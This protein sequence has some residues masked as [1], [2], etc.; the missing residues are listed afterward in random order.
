MIDSMQTN[1]VRGRSSFPDPQPPNVNNNSNNIFFKEYL[2]HMLFAGK[3]LNFWEKYTLR[4]PKWDG[5]IYLGKT[6]LLMSE[7]GIGDEIIAIRFQK[8]ISDL[9][10]NC[11]WYTSRKD[12]AAVFYQ[13][14]FNVITSLNEIKNDWLWIQAMEA[15]VWLD[16]DYNQVYYGPYLKAKGSIDKL[17]GK[18]KIGLKFSGNLEYDQQI[19]RKIPSD[20]LVDCMPNN[21]TLY[22]FQVFDDEEFISNK[23]ILLRDRI[24]SWEDTLN[25][26]D[27]MDLIVSNCT[28]LP[29]ASSAMGKKTI[30]IVPISSYYIWEKET[31]HS[32][33]Y[34]KSTLILRQKQY[35]NFE[36]PLNQL[37][38]Y[39]IEKVTYDE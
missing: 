32:N 24:S 23:V 37:K 26:I 1:I 34:G 29:H 36:E 17:P 30:V 15:P 7:A 18:Y 2:K 5:K 6:I 27:Q 9:G 16:L 10:M 21:A 22:S 11:V 38:K 19:K 12:L 28:S 20:L 8:H 4:I 25:Y 13:N 35:D 31:N 3:L 14:G 39:L 33:W